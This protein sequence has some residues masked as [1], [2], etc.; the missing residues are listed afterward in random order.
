LPNG[1]LGSDSDMLSRL[2]SGTIKF[3]TASGSAV[4]STVVPVAAINA[5]A[6]LSRFQGLW[7]G[8]GGDGWR[9]WRPLRGEIAKKGLHALP[10][11]YD[12][13]FRQVTSALCADGCFKRRLNKL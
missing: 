9:F 13:G 6:S 10:N 7:S 12:N 11:A 1:Q 8:L 3:Y 4:L 2:R 5:R